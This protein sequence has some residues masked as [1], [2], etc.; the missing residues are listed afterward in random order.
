MN[1]GPNRLS[2]GRPKMS[3]STV[4]ASD[5]QNVHLIDWA[6]KADSPAWSPA[7]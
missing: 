1:C 2:I 6:M 3:S 7:T 4:A 5:G